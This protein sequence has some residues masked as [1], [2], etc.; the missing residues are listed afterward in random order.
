MPHFSA[1]GQLSITMFTRPKPKKY[2]VSTTTTHSTP[3]CPQN[4]QAKNQF[5]PPQPPSSRPL[6]PGI[7]SEI[8]YSPPHR[9]LH[10]IRTGIEFPSILTEIANQTQRQNDDLQQNELPRA[11]PFS[12]L[13]SLHSFHSE[14]IAGF[15]K[16]APLILG[17]NQPLLDQQFD[18]W[19]NREETYSSEIAEL[20]FRHFWREYK[21]G[22]NAHEL[23][24][25]ALSIGAVAV[26]EI[27]CE[28]YFSHINK[29]YTK[30]RRRLRPDQVLAEL[31]VAFHTTLDSR[32]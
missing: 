8:E 21:D 4:P 28:R 5:I 12:V 7:V 32:Q 16:Y 23:G 22:A 18:I 29:I 14:I 1:K 25:L 31:S 27:E 13:S 30:S 6:F 17:R 11:P 26:S 20:T 10:G 15:K 9:H 2:I 24:D 3:N 19:L